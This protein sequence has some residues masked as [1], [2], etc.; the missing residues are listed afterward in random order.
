MGSYNVQLAFAKELKKLAKDFGEVAQPPTH[1]TVFALE[2]VLKTAFLDTQ[3]KVH[4]ITA[5]LK[6]SGKTS[7]DFTADDE[8]TGEITYGGVSAGVNNPVDYALYE[9]ERGGEHDFFRDLP[10]YDALYEDAIYTHFK[11]LT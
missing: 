10:K 1:K 7:S 5:S 8:W 6:M 2:T 11:V 9:M 3:E 4:V